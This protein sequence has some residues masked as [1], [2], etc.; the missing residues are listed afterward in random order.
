[1]AESSPSLLKSKDSYDLSSTI[2]NGNYGWFGIIITINISY[3]AC[4]GKGKAMGERRW[5]SN[6]GSDNHSALKIIC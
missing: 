6:N 4:E 2:H 3:S 1:M 5:N